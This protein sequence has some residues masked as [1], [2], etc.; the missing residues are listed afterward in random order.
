[1]RDCCKYNAGM[2]RDA[3]E[4]ERLGTVDQA[5]GGFDET[6]TAISG[7]PTRGMFKPMSG[8]EVWQAQRQSAE[9]KN[10][11]VVRYFSGIT[12]ADRVKVRGRV[13]AITYVPDI[14]ARDKWLEID[15][16]GGVAP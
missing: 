12:A 3:V 7:A 4:F 8:G 11:L 15:L 16:A 9:S 10:R 5:N 1:M 14:D 6:W 13:Y 2:L